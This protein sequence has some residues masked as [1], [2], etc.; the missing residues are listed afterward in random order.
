MIP[1]SLIGPAATLAVAAIGA[2]GLII[3]R[4]LRGPV[5]VQDLWAENRSLRD[6]LTEVSRKVD[7]LVR[8]EQVQ[9]GVNR[10][11][12]E[13]FDALSGYVERTSDEAGIKPA[14]TRAEHESIERA[15]ALRGDDA[16]WPTGNR[17]PI[18]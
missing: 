11:M 18:I 8:N 2:L 15:R 3:V 13:G 10:I 14:Y 4:R 12:G 7:Q 1:E 9:L 5:T 17:V 16:I 6:D